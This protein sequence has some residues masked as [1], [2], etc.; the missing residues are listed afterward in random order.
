MEPPTL[1]RQEIQLRLFCGKH[2]SAFKWTCLTCTFENKSYWDICE[3]CDTC[4]IFQ[5][6]D[7]KKVPLRKKNLL[8]QR[9]YSSSS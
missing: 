2:R 1:D 9:S 5:Q 3:L 8:E 4:R 7:T 6:G